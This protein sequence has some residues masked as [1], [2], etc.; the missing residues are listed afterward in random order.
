RQAH[1]ADVERDAEGAAGFALPRAASTRTA[2]LDQGGLAADGNGPRG[3]VLRPDPRRPEAARQ[4]AGQLDAPV[5]RHRAGGAD[6]VTEAEHD[7][8]DRHVPP[9]SALAVSPRARGPRPRTRAALPRRRP[10]RR[11]DRLGP[12]A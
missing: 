2:R 8:L 7:A 10:D 3:Q 9:A 5:G 1:P 6:D 12:L 11:A 4:G